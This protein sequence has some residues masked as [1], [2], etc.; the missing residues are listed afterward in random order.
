M[1][2]TVTLS[3]S[4]VRLEPLTAHHAD[5]LALTTND[6]EKWRYHGVG[7]L[8]SR[9]ALD[10]FIAS[11]QDEPAQGI[12]LNFAIVRVD[13]G[14]AYGATALWDVSLP[15]LRGEIG[16]TWLAPE[17]RR[18]GI[19][20]EA[21]Y[22]LLEYAFETLGLLRVQLK[23]DANNT[24]SRRAIERLGAIEEGTLRAHMILHNGNRRD[25]V[26]YSILADEWISE[27]KARL[28]GMMASRTDA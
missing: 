19:N 10:A 17:A 16:R 1:L 7:D 28:L 18:T 25:T 11:V 4:L 23:T 24:V 2:Q 22:L 5:D 6:P 14:R 3:G 8:T 21:K 9:A 26:Y 15:N 13:T 12:G 20:T 27:V